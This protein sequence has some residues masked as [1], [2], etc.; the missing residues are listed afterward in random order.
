MNQLDIPLQAAFFRQRMTS[1]EAVRFYLEGGKA[2]L[3]L[4]SK[5]TGRRFTY[6]FSRP[7]E[8]QDKPRPIWISVLTGADNESSY[9]FACT[10]WPEDFSALRFSAKS[11][12]TQ[13]APSIKMLAW[14][15]RL[16]YHTDSAKHFSLFSQAEVWHEGRCGRC[17]RK[18]TVPESVASGFGPEC[19]G[20]MQ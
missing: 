16:L 1:T 12:I 2:T 5:H 7:V 4:V 17:G 19:A 8:Q 15:M 3:T 11:R 9:T 14:F 6:R 20:R 13:E 10:V 18:L